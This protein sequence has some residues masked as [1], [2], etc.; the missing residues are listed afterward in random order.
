MYVNGNQIVLQNEI[1]LKEFLKKEGYDPLK[2]AVE[3]N[4]CIVPGK[5]YET[6]PLTDED[7]LEIVTFVGGG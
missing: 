6:E 1:T 5:S 7:R 2:V 4:G 3:K